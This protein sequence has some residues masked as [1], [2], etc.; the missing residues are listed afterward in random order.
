[1]TNLSQKAKENPHR[2]EGVLLS[3]CT[4]NVKNGEGPPINTLTGVLSVTSASLASTSSSNLHYA[5]I[6]KNVFLRGYS[7]TSDYY[8]QVILW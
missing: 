3:T 1:L 4:G 2:V 8:L 5:T 6:E 7:G